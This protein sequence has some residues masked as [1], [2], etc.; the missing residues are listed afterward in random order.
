M[1]VLC[2]LF[3]ACGL[4][5]AAQTENA[6]TDGTSRPGATQ[7]KDDRLEGIDE[8]LRK[9][10]D[11]LKDAEEKRSSEGS[12]PRTRSGA[13][14]EPEGP[15]TAQPPGVP[16]EAYWENGLRFRTEDGAFEGHVGG[17]VLVHGRTVFDRP[18]DDSAPLRSV[19]D[20]MFFR[21][22][23]LQVD[24]TAYSEFYFK[25]QADFSTG[26]FNQSTGADPSNV[27]GSLR[28]AYIEWRRW[29]EFRVRLGQYYQ[30]ISQ[31]DMTSV[32]FIDF[33]E[34]SAMN[35]LLPG[36]ELGLKIHG[37][38]EDGL[39]S[40]QVMLANGSALTNDKGRSVT[41]REDEKQVAG[42]AYV[43]PFRLSGEPLLDGLRLGIGGS[44]EDVDSIA[45][46]DFDLITKELSVLYLD[47]T[48]GGTFDG[49]RSRL[50]PQVSW[51]I[52][53]VSLRGEYVIRRDELD[54]TFLDNQLRSSG[55]YAYGTW[56]VTGE[57]KKPATRV[58][59][60]SDGGAVELAFRAAKLRVSNP[61]SSGLAVSSGNSDGVF[62]LTAGVNWWIRSNIRISLNVIRER[63]DDE[64]QFDTRREDTLMGSLL[65]V[66][67]DF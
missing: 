64:L 29:P 42:V 37:S 26:K 12:L 24:G 59:P 56:L 39:F 44:V 51:T 33:N 62:I 28:D 43:M 55:W 60:E 18:D 19:P 45:A 22:A 52:G 67:V 40:Y 2:G 41:D 31:E 49:R 11:L 14:Q 13:R 20:S 48:A 65:R 27:R 1:M 50:V 15:V 38:I 30:P 23:Y 16:L 4:A 7:E 21:E 58:T 57:D 61:F 47:S 10:E 53:P 34:R 32:R 5:A 66:Q 17:R 8:R 6:G 63:Y 36:R 3:L 54:D 25:V 46:S 35:N 9:V